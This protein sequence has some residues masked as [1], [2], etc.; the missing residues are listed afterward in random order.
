M[1]IISTESMNYHAKEPEAF[2]KFSEE[3]YGFQITDA[4]LGIV[5]ENKPIVLITGPSGSGKTVTAHRLRAELEKTG[6]KTHIISMD[7]YFLPLES[8]IEGVDLESPERVDLELFGRQSQKILRC[9][10][11]T[12]P[13]FNFTNQSRSDGARF[14][15]GE[16][17][18]VIFEGIHM[19]NPLVAGS[20][21][22]DAASVYVSVRTRIKAQSTILHPSK[23]RLMRRFVRDKLYRGR[24]LVQTIEF[25][26]NVE[27]GEKLYI[28][29]F[30]HLADFDIDTFIAY[31][32]SVYK[33][34][35]FEEIKANAG[36]GCPIT[37]ELLHFLQELDCVADEFVPGR[38][39]VREFI[40]GNELME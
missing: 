28:M 3:E 29:P 26:E 7:N 32:P 33:K 11:I 22:K 8:G 38:S 35:I 12:L 34:H 9:E 1:R 4:A 36:S 15:R 2:V 5:E 23:V 16:G 30:K 18:I 25:F 14:R 20:L 40:G 39:P 27:R 6:H 13:V 19:L 31:E 24:E 21:S 37:Q 17:E 10:E